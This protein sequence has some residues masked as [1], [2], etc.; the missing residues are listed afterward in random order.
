MHGFDPVGSALIVPG[1]VIAE[2]GFLIE[3]AGGPHAEAEFLSSLTS[4]KYE[5][6]APT[7]KE[8]RRVLVLTSQRSTES[9]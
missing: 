6:V 7:P 5:V 4:P 8:L 3:R 2:A 1:P 9:G